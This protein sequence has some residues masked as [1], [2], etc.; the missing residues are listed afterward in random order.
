MLPERVVIAANVVVRRLGNEMVLLDLAS[1]TYFGLNEVG[2]RVWDLLK[3]G[4]PPAQIVQTLGEEFD[5]DSA[6][7]ERDLAVLLDTLATKGLVSI[8]DPR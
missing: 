4:L 5:A 1:G 2:A 6:T 3:S 7:I 8:A